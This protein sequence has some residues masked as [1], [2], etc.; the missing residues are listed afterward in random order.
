[1]FT[2]QS[3]GTKYSTEEAK[4]MVV[5]IDTSVKL[6]NALKNARRARECKDYEQ[7][8]KYY[9]IVQMEDPENWEANFYSTYSK[10]YLSSNVSAVKNCIKSV[11]KDIKKLNDSIQQN[12]A[13]EQISTDIYTLASKTYDVLERNKNN[14][15][16]SAQEILVVF[17]ETLISEFGENEFTNS[18]N[19]RCNEIAFE[20]LK[21]FYDSNIIDN[22]EIKSDLKN[23]IRQNAEEL[24]KMNPKS[25]ELEIYEAAMKKE[26]MKRID[27]YYELEAAEKKEKIGR[28]IKYLIFVFIFC[29]CIYICSGVFSK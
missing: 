1:M 22:L 2:C 20:L 15:K 11:L 25:H 12:K 28:L 13:I 23:L 16:F 18:I 8:E 6:E 27:E 21:K 9:S 24:R 14:I 10:A 3:C 26:A 19:I 5:T 7:A 29:F 4:K 17:G